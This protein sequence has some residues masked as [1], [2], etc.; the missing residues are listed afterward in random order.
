MRPPDPPPQTRDQRGLF[1]R[2]QARATGLSAYRIRG[3]VG[4]GRWLPVLGDVLAVAGRPLG[5]TDRFA[6]ATLATGGV[7]SHASAAELWAMPVP[8]SYG[9]IHVTTPARHHT[10]VPGVRTHRRPLADAEHLLV[11]GVPT[12][13][14][15]RTLI[16]CLGSMPMPAALD[17]LDEAFRRAWISVAG[18]REQV[19]AAKH[20]HG[21][22]HLSRI[23]DEASTGGWSEAERRLH[24]LLVDAGIGGWTA[25]ARVDLGDGTTACPDIWF[26]AQRLAIEVDGRAWHVSAA[27]F[28]HDR[29]RQNRLVLCGCIVL[30]F[31]W[32]DL[33]N[34][35][36]R[37][38]QTI[39]L[40]LSGS[41]RSELTVG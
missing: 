11:E 36:E 32:A 41:N 33:V 18:L 2:R 1:T 16:D 34:G 27:Q 8:R 37:V 9:V 26:P 15:T 35:P 28:Q 24:R 31:T 39:R 23:L 21:V 5:R 6:A 7:L 14:R 13:S 3:L 10:E 19:D 17:L 40:A 25:N 29:T 38:L 12:T 30:R 4:S 22:R 20:R